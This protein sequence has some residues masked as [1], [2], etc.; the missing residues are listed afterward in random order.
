[1]AAFQA[2]RSAFTGVGLIS[3][4]SNIL[5]LTGPFFML[6]IYDRVLPSR[7]VPTLIGL[8][9]LAGLMYVF[10][11]LLEFF[12]GRIV[13]RIGAMLDEALNRRVFDALVRLPLKAKALGDGL[14]PLRDLDQLRSFLSS[15]G[16]MALFDFPW[17][18]IYLAICFVF[19]PLIGF[20]ATVGGI[21]LVT[22][23]VL[24][25][26][27]TRKPVND[28]VVHAAMRNSLGGESRRNA[29]V[30]QAMGMADKVG[31]IW[32]LA[33]ERYM[34]SQRTASDVAGAFGSVSKVLRIAL[35]SAILGIGAWLVLQQQATAGIIIASSILTSRALA[36]VEAAIANCKGF[37]TAR[38]SWRRLSDL[39]ALLPAREQVMALPAPAKDLAVEGIAVVPPGGRLFVVQDIT[40]KLPAGSALGIIG[41]NAAGK[42]SLARALVGVWSPVRGVIRLDG[43]SLD[44]W[45]V[46][47]LGRHIG[48]VPQDV[49]LFDGTIAENIARFDP[50]PDS[51]NVIAAAESAGVSKMIR[52][53]PNGYETR[54]GEAGQLLSAGQRQRIALARAL[55]GD[56]FLIVLDE[57]DSNLDAEGYSAVTNA[58]LRQRKRG[59]IAVVVAH[60]ARGL[61]AVDLVLVMKD[62]KKLDFGPKAAIMTKLLG[63]QPPSGV[64]SP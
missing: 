49:Q 50:H 4:V 64:P 59:G 19:H 33:N 56:P 21:I 62:G 37:L 27:F 25:E 41:P 44:H 36:P 24:T 7:S 5:M 55:Y 1:M 23:T 11:G 18:P 32:G 40:F 39:L 16:P 60:Q 6:E 17:I 48:Y 2:C 52:D 3:F 51:K 12:R 47:T 53:M 15:T 14:Q 29:D 38:Q 43:T 9:I 45:D 10:Q 30:L 63:R 35:Q 57:P 13:I 28:T 54:I 61:E 22:L 34:S 42:S 58:I 20:A 31:A 8:A 46:T 26:V